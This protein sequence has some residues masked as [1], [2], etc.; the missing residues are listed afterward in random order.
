MH[1]LSI[2][3]EP[4]VTLSQLVPLAQLAENQSTDTGEPLVTLLVGCPDGRERSVAFGVILRDMIQRDLEE[5]P[6][7]TW[8]CAPMGLDMPWMRVTLALEKA[9]PAWVAA[10]IRAERASASSGCSHA[11]RRWLV[12]D[13]IAVRAMFS[14]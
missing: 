3:R 2:Y 12:I 1:N 11:A 4:M 7:G 9:M 14:A 8:K 5:L 10:S 6:W 13:R